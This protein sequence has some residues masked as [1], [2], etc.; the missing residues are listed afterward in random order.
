MKKYL[1]IALAAFALLSC[2]KE[3]TTVDSE[4]Q[5]KSF[6]YVFNVDEKP[7]FD[8][9]TRAVKASWEAGDQIFIVFDDADP[10]KWEDLMILTHDGEEW[11]VTQEPAANKPK[12][13]GGT[14]S[15][16]YCEMPESPLIPFPDFDA[17][18][19]EAEGFGQYM[20]GNGI[21]YT[22]EDETLTASIS[23]DFETGDGM[24]YVQ[25][26][27]TDLPAS[28]KGWTLEP[29]DYLHEDENDFDV[30]LPAW[31]HGELMFSHLS[32][33]DDVAG[34]GYEYRMGNRDDGY[35][36]YLSVQQKADDITFTITNRDNNEKYRK[37]FSRKISGKCAAV[38]FKG[39][40]LD[41]DGTP[42]NGWKKV[43]LFGLTFADSAVEK[44]CIDNWDA[45]K[46]GYLTYEEAA[47]VSDLGE[48]FM[49][50]TEI[51]SF[52][53]FQYFTGIQVLSGS[54]FGGCTSLQS[55]I[56]PKTL[57]TIKSG[58]F[59]GTGLTSIV[60]PASVS[61]IESN[62]FD[63]CAALETIIVD[64]NNEFFDSRGDCNAIVTKKDY[65]YE[66]NDQTFSFGANW[67]VVGCKNT[68][69]P[70]SV[71]TIYA[72]FLNC[73]GLKSIVIPDSV[74]KITS[75]AFFGCSG[76]ETIDFG[77]GVK[78][79]D[80]VTFSNCTAL[81][82]VVLPGSLESM[83]LAFSECYSLES[84][85]IYALTPPAGFAPFPLGNTSLVIYVPAESLEDYKSADNWKNYAD[86]IQAIPIINGH[87]YVDMGGA[88]KWATMNVGAESPEGF[89]DYFAWGETASKDTYYSSNY[90]YTGESRTLPAD[91][92]AATV[93][94]GS[95]W[96]TPTEDEWTMLKNKC[97]WTWTK[98]NNVNGYLV[99]SKENGNSIFIPASGFYVDNEYYGSGL[100]GYYW[101]SSCNEEILE[102]YAGAFGAV[103]DE[104]Y[105][106]DFEKYA[107]LPVRP[108]V[109]E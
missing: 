60:I 99:T 30:F 14:L 16:L 8:G 15:A 21:P 27:I 22:V 74:T 50:N 82:E 87:E 37:T 78:I 88:G 89:G 95:P 54:A 75:A 10:S 41:A 81:K 58:A 104:P 43:P 36:L 7:S 65:S 18:L 77:N 68:V 52:D 66:F 107:G 79:L 101:A 67:L 31:L 62:P 5:P 97:T 61:C 69:I 46:D 53:E 57:T 76:L 39:P 98:E 19:F 35:Y 106:T 48:A 20:S 84:V 45:D 102:G 6:K 100:T 42:T 103:S 108:L 40:Q 91:N 24:T 55:V 9:N 51:T 29:D 1:L 33:S 83:T 90:S 71:V 59:V 2:N 64:E 49:E 86:M 17:L 28:T 32:L 93:N 25:L 12:D 63:S 96:R 38:T 44:I 80:P 4:L 11:V 109:A 47:A 56:L 3:R 105:L 23:L 70:E 26:R 94:W 34:P 92:D 73:T 72:A 13:T 85:T